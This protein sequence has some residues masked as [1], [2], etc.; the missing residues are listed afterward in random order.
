MAGPHTALA[1]FGDK[2][3]GKTGTLQL[4]LGLFCDKDGHPVSREVVPGNTPE[5]RTFAAQLVKGK[6]RVGAPE[7]PCV[8]D[9]G[10]IKDQQIDD[11]VQPG[12]HASP[13][14]P[15]PA[16][17]T[18]LRTGPLQ[19]DLCAQALAEGLTEE[20]LRYVRGVIPCVPKQCGTPGT[21]H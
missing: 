4:V 7:I 2:R 21:R 10:R 17:E 5:P 18:L 12:F 16:I 8:G 9:R 1:A 19:L 15:K 13:A 11:L 6:S 20:G 14:I 3:A